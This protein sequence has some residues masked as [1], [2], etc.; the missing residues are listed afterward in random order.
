MSENEAVLIGSGEIARFMR[1]SETSL[2]R[3]RRRHVDIPI[4][5]EGKRGPL[6]ADKETLAGWQKRLYSGK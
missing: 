1:I 6:C 4:Y 5:Q 2:S 3:L